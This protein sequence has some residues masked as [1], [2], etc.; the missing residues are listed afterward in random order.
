MLREGSLIARCLTKY[1]ANVTGHASRSLGH[2]HKQYQILY[3][4]QTGSLYFT[5][6]RVE[7]TIHRLNNFQKFS[8]INSKIY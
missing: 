3:I 1:Y 5:I 4:F 2:F 7:V 6:V 8:N